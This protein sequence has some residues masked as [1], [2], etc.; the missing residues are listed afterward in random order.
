MRHF[1]TELKA[2][3]QDGQLCTF[4]GPVIHEI[5]I[6]N[7]YNY[8]QNNGLGYLRITGELYGYASLNAKTSKIELVTF[9]QN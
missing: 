2:L 8:C 7:A 4:R 6:I 3:N 5:S 9:E 1:T